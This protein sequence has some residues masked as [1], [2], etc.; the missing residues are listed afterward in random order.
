MSNPKTRLL[1]LIAALVQCSGTHTHAGDAA[2]ASTPAAGP[3]AAGVP[4]S[5]G[6][7]TD[8]VLNLLLEKGMITEDEAAKT[9][10]QADALRTNMAALYATENSKWKF[11]PS[12]KDI[13]LY[14]DLRAR[15]EGRREYTPAGG[16]INQDRFRYS[17]RLGLRGDVFDDFYYGVRMETSANP[18]STWV[19]MSASSPDPYGKSAAGINIGQVYLGWQPES[20]LDLTV[21]KMPNPLY[22]SSML[23]SSS[24]NPE[25]LS[26]RLKYTIGD[27][28][29]FV[30]MAQFLYQDENPDNATRGLFG[31]G[32]N[33]GSLLGQTAD[34]IVQVAWGG[35]MN[36]R[37]T[38][39][40]SAKA[41]VNLYKYYGMRKSTANQAVSPYFGD[42]YVGEGAYLGGKSP[43]PYNG[44]SGFGG[45]GILPGYQSANYPNNQVGLDYLTVLEI[46]FEINYHLKHVDL[47]A[48]GDIAYNLQGAQRARAAAAGYAAYLKYQ[49]GPPNNYT[50]SVK[51]FSPQT[52][53]YK[54]YQF[55][56]EVADKG[57]L[58]MVNGSTAKRF[59]WDAKT[60]WQHIEQ[61]SLDPNLLDLDMF[62]GA[63]NLE[64]IYGAIAFGLSDNFIATVRY[65]YASRINHKLGTGGTGTDIPQINPI[66]YYN[67]FQFD[68]TYKF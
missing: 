18:R 43:F 41:G 62:A 8:P 15:Y 61:Y 7:T 33:A 23:W 68:L 63:E 44:Y 53:D 25:G 64:G 38:K 40:L 4:Q 55:G 19:T 10:A 12:I 47:R 20:W 9:Q 1:I 51:P 37:V 11:A 27:L 57:C 39:D 49:A 36:Y 21:G 56:F 2:K 58:G 28:D 52:H 32:Q 59:G 45:S 14:G 35:G 3:S 54:A 26:E 65:G 16:R 5:A 48:F 13:E 29:V 60:Y 24:I 66:N 30:N 6:G 50:V 22:T 46:P 42:V 31:S 17:V 67:L 34:N